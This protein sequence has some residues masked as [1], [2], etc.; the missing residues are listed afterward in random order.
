M[1]LLS[2]C[3]LL[4]CRL[5]RFLIAA[6]D[7]LLE[8]GDRRLGRRS[9]RAWP[10]WLNHRSALLPVLPRRLATGESQEQDPRRWRC[11][12]ESTLG[13]T[14]RGE[15]ARKKP[16][17]TRPARYS[18]SINPKAKGALLSRAKGLTASALDGHLRSR[19]PRPLPIGRRSCAV[20][21]DVQ[22]GY[23]AVV[24]RPGLR[25]NSVVSTYE[26][27]GSLRQR[28]C[29]SSRHAALR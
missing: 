12:S 21:R 10:T 3:A 27:C 4:A 11:M 13:P 24:T 25:S 7:L 22:A 1:L 17:V 18:S 23:R 9:P 6:R 5:L 19:R 15:P 14:Q 28:G 16:S 29:T 26:L 8:L 2:R 20:L